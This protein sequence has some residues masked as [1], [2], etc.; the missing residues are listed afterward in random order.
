M[1]RKHINKSNY[2]ICDW[3]GIPLV[4]NK[5]FCPITKG[6]RH[7]KYGCFLNW[8]CVV[9]YLDHTFAKEKIDMWK[10]SLSKV[11]EVAGYLPK[12]APSFLELQH[13]GGKM[14]I[15]EF[16]EACNSRDD[17]IKGV[18]IATTGEVTEVKVEANDIDTNVKQILGSQTYDTVRVQKK[19]K[20]NN[21]TRQLVILNDLTATEPNHHVSQFFKNL[22]VRIGGNVLLLVMKSGLDKDYFTSFD[23]TEFNMN[24]L[25]STPRSRG[26]KRDGALTVEEFHQQKAAMQNKLKTVTSEMPT[27]VS[28]DLEPVSK[29]RRKNLS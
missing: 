16:Q 26:G 14:T 7:V 9:A 11:E 10:A 21:K 12:P 22:G 27:P 2:Y 19:L 4:H 1:R 6:D 5:C 18:C 13:F 24:F 29:R 15:A 8:E 23:M 17:I 25:P 28:M 3:T 20:T